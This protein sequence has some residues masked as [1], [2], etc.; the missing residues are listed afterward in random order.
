MNP[1]VKKALIW[2]FVGIMLLLMYIPILILI[3]YS[4]TDARALGVWS[5]FSFKLYAKLFTDSRI[6]SAL[7]NSL[8]LATISAALATILG[9]LAAIGIFYMKKRRKRAA[10]FIANITMENAEIVT[11]VAFMMFF[12]AIKLPY[13]WVTLIIAHTVIAVPY[14]ILSVTPKLT[15]LNPNLYEAGLDLGASPVKSLFTVIVPQLIPGMISGFIMAFTLSLDEFIVSK[16]ICG[17]VQ[18]IPI[19]LYNALAKKGVDPTLRALSAVLFIAVLAVL[20][21]LN[22]VSAKRKKKAVKNY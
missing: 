22:V 19:Y 9:T 11:G 8:L 3:V 13:G 6:M 17:S 18:T 5:G 16:F 12:L 14:V 7:G 10:D 2:A 15:Q 1:R 4:F 20:I 21:V